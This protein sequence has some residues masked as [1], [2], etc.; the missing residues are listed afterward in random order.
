MKKI[1]IVMVLAF[2]VNGY[3]TVSAQ[4]Q[5]G[6]EEKMAMKLTSP[7]FENMK[8][9]PSKFTCDGIDINPPLKIENVP[10]GAKSLALIV[11]D[12]DAPAKVWVHWV[13][14]DIDPGTK[15]IPEN[16]IPGIQG[17][18][19]SN[20][21]NYGGPCPPSGTHRYY[22]KLYAL[23]KMLGF[24]EGA[25]KRKV[26]KAIEGHILAKDELVGLYKRGGSK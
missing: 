20:G 7:S 26:E 11:D 9:I 13:V 2:I 17:V 8:S 21:K 23:D 18:N 19:D 12:P 16:S 6:K 14:Y 1:I 15:A 24:I 22:F 10:S 5:D 3:F 25:D 4:P